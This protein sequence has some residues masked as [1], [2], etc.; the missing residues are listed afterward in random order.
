MPKFKYIAMDAKGKETEGVLDAENQ[1]QAVSLIRSK[2]FFPTRVL[3][4]SGGGSDKKKGVVTAAVNTQA[5]AKGLRKSLSSFNLFGGTI[6]PKHLMV[7]TR[8]LATL[9]GAGMPLLR[10]LRILLK[11]EKLPALR[12]AL[13]GMGEAVESGSTFSEALAQ[14]PKIFDKLFINMVKAGEA[15]GVLEVVLERL[16]EFM[17]KSE[18]IKN[19]DK[20]AMIYPIVV[21]VAALGIVGFLMT[22]VI[23][24][25]QEIFKDLLQGKPLP[26]LTQFVITIS[27]AVK[28]QGL[29]IIGVIAVIVVA[30]KLW[31]KTSAG[32]VMLDKMK[33]KIPMFGTLLVKSAVARFTR[34]LGTLMSSG[35]PVLQALNIVRETAG[36]EAV[37][38][39]ILQVHDAVK[40]GESMS[41]PL[42]A[43]GV[44]PGM[45]VS[46]VDVGEE[47]GALPEML[48]RIAD[49]YDDEVDSAVEG[50]TSIIE[51]IMIVFLAVV[52]GTIVIAMFVPLISIISEMGK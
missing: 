41:M 17:E 39:A 40:E 49:N 25:F 8:Q 52:V 30:I 23:P 22:N 31:G 28:T 19:K 37:A 7:F 32:R 29:V 26:A 18:K 21:L 12:D 34:T 5:Q 35:V 1:S 16:A 2:G 9:V 47:T 42:E 27:N 51:P 50:L 48:T 43:S 3:D 44:F 13:N 6:K 4:V 20:G 11:Q 45:V 36:N 24:K 46:M 15:G 10:G 33:L 14:Y 38:K